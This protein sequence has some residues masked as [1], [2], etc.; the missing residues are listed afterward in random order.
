MQS[1]ATPLLQSRFSRAEGGQFTFHNPDL[2]GQSV[3]IDVLEDGKPSRTV[4]LKLDR[5]G[6]AEFHMP[7]IQG[8]RVQLR[9]ASSADFDPSAT[10]IATPA[11][12][13]KPADVRPAERAASAPHTT[14]SHSPS[15]TPSHGPG[16]KT[17]MG[18]PSFGGSGSSSKSG[19]PQ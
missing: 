18:N 19:A 15:A 16:G 11:A 4:Q 8:R 12:A 13:P 17:V 2:A 14:S 3:D 1:M 5:A 10:P 6:R 7:P 9:H